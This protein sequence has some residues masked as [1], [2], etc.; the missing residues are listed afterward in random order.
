MYGVLPLIFRI[1]EIAIT[2]VLLMI[3]PNLFGLFHSVQNLMCSIS[4]LNSK[5]LLKDTLIAI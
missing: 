2:F 1:M 4:L 3:I 5:P